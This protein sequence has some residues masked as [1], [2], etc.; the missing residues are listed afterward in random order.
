MVTQVTVTED[1]GSVTVVSTPSNITIS[2]ESGA[3]IG[4]V[5]SI[6]NDISVSSSTN[7]ITVGDAVGIVPIN[8]V[9]QDGNIGGTYAPDATLGLI[10]LSTITSDITDLNINIAL[11]FTCRLLITQD[12]T[13]GWTLDTTT[14]PANWTDWR[15]TNNLT[16]LDPDVGETTL[17]IVTYDG[18]YYNAELQRFDADDGLAAYTTDNLVEGNVNLYYTE[19]RGN[20]MVAAYQGEIDTAGNISASNIT[21]TAYFIGDGSLLTN[22]RDH[23]PEL[24]GGSA[25][26]M[27]LID[28]KVLEGGGAFDVYLPGQAVDGGAP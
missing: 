16:I 8:T 2:D 4:N 25:A 10:H 14:T 15:F 18:T 1:P 22:I 21:S 26:E 28:D 24:D 11:G 19:T 12:A 3:V 6:S 7:T 9:V 13:G 23:V 20:A 17:V 27:Y 5:T